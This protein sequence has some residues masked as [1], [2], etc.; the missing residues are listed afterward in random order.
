M[1]RQKIVAKKLPPKNCSRYLNIALTRVGALV[2]R[3]DGASVKV[4]ARLGVSVGCDGSELGS[5]DG[6][7]LGT[8][9]TDGCSEG[10]PEGGNVGSRVGGC[11]G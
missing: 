8:V 10:L 4:G 3:C 2:G 5:G 1:C 7:M 9:D 11:V 6:N